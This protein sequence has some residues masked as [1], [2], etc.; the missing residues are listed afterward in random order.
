MSKEKRFVFTGFEKAE[1][2]DFELGEPGEG[3]VLVRTTKSMISPGTEGICFS[4]LFA[5]GTHYDAWVQYPFYPGYI[6][7]GTVEKC[8]PKVTTLS[9][10]DRV[11][12]IEPHASAV[13]V[14][15][16]ACCKIPEQ[17]PDEIAIWSTFAKITAMGARAAAYTL[18][19][20][21]AVIGAGPIG[22]FSARWARVA[23]ANVVMIDTVKMRLDLAA[24]AGIGT[25][26]TSADKALQPLTDYFGGVQP[27]IVIDSTG[28]P[29]VFAQ[30]LALPRKFGKVV[31]I[32][33]VGEPAK[34]HLTPD[35]INRGI[36]IVGCHVLH[37]TPDW[38]TKI[39]TDYFFRL[40]LDGR[41]NA[42]G[43]ITHQ[44]PADDPQ[45]IYMFNKE[46]RREIMGVI[47]DWRKRNQ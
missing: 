12:H 23:G 6:M 9:P 34:Q 31:L 17:L 26:E 36:T 38:N 43:L 14:K 15:A 25:L 32:G 16:D 39:I 24:R 18:N 11:V 21:V 30:T 40:C 28:I 33:D 10:G 46:H 8:G 7:T 3:Q 1:L 27:D 42:D 2:Q 45:K 13:I 41:M 20:R 37:D 35:V 44:F 19:A 22:Q 29:A 4:R 5:P 47:V